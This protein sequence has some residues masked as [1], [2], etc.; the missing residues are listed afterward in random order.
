MPPQLN[1]EDSIVSRSG[2]STN[3]A[4]TSRAGATYSQPTHAG[5]RSRPRRARLRTVETGRPTGRASGSST[6]V[7]GSGRDIRSVADL[8]LVVALHGLQET[9]RRLLAGEQLLQLRCPA[10]RVDGAGGVRD[11]VH[12]AVV[13]ADRRARV[14]GARRDGVGLD[15]RQLRVRRPHRVRAADGDGDLA[16]LRVRC[17]PVE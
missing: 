12:R 5:V 16:G 6:V 17:D 2:R 9:F 4:K 8:A 1:S 15:R 7:S 14:E 10:L 3:T 13:L 11:E